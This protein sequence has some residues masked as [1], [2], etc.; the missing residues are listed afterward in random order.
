MVRQCETWLEQ[1]DSKRSSCHVCTYP[2]DPTKWVWTWVCPQ[3]QNTPP[4][5]L[6]ITSDLV[7]RY[8]IALLWWRELA[9]LLSW[10]SCE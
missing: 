9:L 10:F 6:L 2:M 1:M 7:E 3:V 5:L 8:I 4:A